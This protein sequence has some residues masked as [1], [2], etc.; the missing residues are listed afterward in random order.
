MR[1][2]LTAFAVLT[3]AAPLSA[4]EITPR[5]EA[6]LA[7]QAAGD[8]RTLSAELAAA[9]AAVDAE[10]N[11]RLE[12]LLPEAPEGM[13][14]TVSADYAAGL[15]MMGGGS[16]A[17]ASYSAEDGS[18]ATVMLNIDT[19]M[20]AGLMRALLSPEMAAFMGQKVELGGLTFFDQSGS[21]TAI[22]DQRLL[23]TVNGGDPETIRKVAGLLDGAAL[24]RFD[25]P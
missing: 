19:P 25:Q 8:L 3:L 16:G 2:A 4:D 10:R 9:S 17:E 6:A 12:A 24:A 23:V 11:R 22:V 5:L 20:I 21:M 13:T 15:A 7:A 1:L 14:R 18:Y